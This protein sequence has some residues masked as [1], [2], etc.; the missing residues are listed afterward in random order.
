MSIAL[1]AGGA[2]IMRLTADEPLFASRSE[3]RSATTWIIALH[4]WE[5]RR[6]GLTTSAAASKIYIYV[7]FYFSLTYYMEVN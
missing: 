4:T 5:T 7:S 3:Q 1:V 2:R 6:D